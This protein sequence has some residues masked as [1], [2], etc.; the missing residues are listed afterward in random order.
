MN[1]KSMT[2]LERVKQWFVLAVPEPTEANQR[3]QLGCH[4]EEVGEMLEV[5][6]GAEDA[7]TMQTKIASEAFKKGH[8]HPL[9][10]E[11]LL[12]EEKAELL[13]SL[14]DQIV[15]AIGVAHMYGLDILPALDAV[16]EA[17]WAKFSGGVPQFD[18]N[19]KIKKPEGWKPADLTPFV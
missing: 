6:V 15:T 16:N 12:T 3:V 2:L 18:A 7:V 1:V 19:G 5:V 8:W 9:F 14:C 13:D 4:L 17:N 10:S 11:E